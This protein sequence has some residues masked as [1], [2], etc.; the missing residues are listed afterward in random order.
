[1]SNST[2]LN[3]FK[4]PDS[5]VNYFDPDLQPPVPLVELPEKLN[6]F[7]KDGV[8][9]YAKMLTA[10]P[11]QNVK[12]L[13]ALNMLLH[14]PSAANKSIVEASS[15]S[16][17]LSLGMAARVLWGNEDVT[18]HVTN[19]KHPDQLRILRFFGLNVSL[20]GG[21]AQ[22]EPVDPRGIMCRL[23]SRAKQDENVCYPGQYDNEHNWRAHTRWTGA[24]IYRQLPEINVLC[25]T[26]GT[27]GCITGTGV[28]LKAQ[29]P[30][31]KVVGV[32]NVF[33]DPT[34][35]PRHFPGFE[36][37]QFPW[38]ETIDVFEDVASV[39]SYEM[40]MRLSREGLIC[41]PSSGEALVGLLNYLRTVKEE[42]ML[43]E[44]SDPKTGEISCVFICCDLPYQYM[45]GY[46]QKLPD[47]KF[48][49]II[50]KVRDIT[51]PLPQSPTAPIPQSAISHT[52]Q[53]LLTCDQNKHDERWELSPNQAIQMLTSRVL[54]STT[55]K[56]LRPSCK[57]PSC[58]RK[59]ICNSS[60]RLSSK[61]S[62][63]DLRQPADFAAGH[64]FGSQSSPLKNLTVETGDVFGDAE[65]LRTMW[66]GLKEKFEGKEA[67]ELLEKKKKG[68]LVVLCYDGETGRLA[69]SLLRKRGVKAFSVRRG[70]EGLRC[71][72]K[73]GRT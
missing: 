7:R 26:I 57:R 73:E 11:A 37:S 71:C 24:Q 72:L 36:S 22:Q 32:C 38:R 66:M 12:V 10:L 15:G 25:T 52:P 2:P 63:L 5:V 68:P 45:D 13:P 34:P 48:P 58:R 65:V 39:D 9:I 64:L 33:G 31:I 23:R 1:M 69:T 30:S 43:K 42:G 44:L 28:H 54:A 17:A 21:L 53:I 55:S 14:Q 18:A 70:W 40:S 59:T 61:I 35:G 6:P 60:S 29:K 47:E 16:T 46:F 41:G 3:V 56:L 8:R 51:T 67:E 4:G 62:I 49:P 19:K 20:Y 50:N 27:G